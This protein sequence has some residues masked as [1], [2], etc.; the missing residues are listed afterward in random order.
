MSHIEKLWLDNAGESTT[1]ASLAYIQD[2]RWYVWQVESFS[3]GSRHV[4]WNSKC[5]LSNAAWISKLMRRIIS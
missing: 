5:M 2:K 4:G 1:V 3:K